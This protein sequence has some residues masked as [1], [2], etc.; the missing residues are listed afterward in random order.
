VEALWPH[1]DPPAATNGLHQALYAAR[2]ALAAG[3]PGP[4]VLRLRLCQGVLALQAPGGLWIDA[5]AFRAA[6]TAARRGRDPA[7]Y[8]AALAL[9]TGD[10]LPEDAY[11][12]WCAA[13]RQALR[14]TFLDLLTEEARLLEDRGALPAAREALQRLVAAEPAHEAA[15]VGLMRLYAAD[16]QRQRALRQFARLRLALRREL[17]AEPDETSRRLYE[18]IAAGRF[19]APPAG[20]A[21]A[22]PPP[23]PAAAG[24]APRPPRRPRH[25]LPRPLK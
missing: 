12:D 2:R 9:Y 16:G 23:P 17:D 11:A 18:A 6:A 5:E 1:L 4:P 19:P 13:P 20:P 21:D 25:N 7:A 10:L 14:E 3:A 22:A 24:G 8:E 15:H